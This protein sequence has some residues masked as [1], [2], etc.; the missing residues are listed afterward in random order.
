M[1]RVSI[2]VAAVPALLALLA[3]CGEESVRGIDGPTTGIGGEYVGHGPPPLF[4]DGSEPIRLT[5]QGGEIG[6]SSGCNQ[7]GGT[8]TWTDGT[9]RT[10]GLGGTEM[11]CEP[12]LHRQ[13]EWLVELFGSG[14]TLEL[15]GTDLVVRS[16]DEE[17]WFVPFD[18]VGTGAPGDATDLVDTHWRLVGIG[19]YDGDM[20]SVMSIPANVEPTIR[21]LADEVGIRPGCNGGGGPV[22]I[23]AGT[24]TFSNDVVLSMRA[25]PDARGEVEHEVMRVLWSTDPVSWSIDGDTL[26]L[27]TRD[28]RHELVYQR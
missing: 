5:L 4:P 9:L 28:G 12:R 21:F 7:F 18:E 13:D 8:A 15:D 1:S 11:G 6:F 10:S 3:A 22:R 2:R 19:E 24:I 27:R 16:G 14:P 26:R 23:E 25:C 20:G 17:V